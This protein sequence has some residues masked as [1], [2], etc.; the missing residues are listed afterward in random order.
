MTRTSASKLEVD[1]KAYMGEYT[2]Y[3]D[4]KA[5]PTKSEKRN[6]T[7]GIFVLSPK[8]AAHFEGLVKGSSYKITEIETPSK[9]VTV[10]AIT[11]KV[12]D[13]NGEAKITNKLKKTVDLKISK[14]VTNKSS[15]T[16]E[17]KF[18]LYLDG[19]KQTKFSYKL[20]NA[21]GTYST[22]TITDG[23]IKIKHGQ[24]ALIEGI[25]SGTKYEVRE[26]DVPD[27][28]T[29]VVPDNF[30]GILENTTEVKYING[31]S[32]EDGYV[33]LR[34]VVVSDDAADYNRQYTVTCKIG[35]NQRYE[36]IKKM[37][38]KTGE[39]SDITPTKKSNG[40]ILKYTRRSN[41]DSG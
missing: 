1:G 34:K 14:T 39:L 40:R 23:N 2:Y 20:Y 38:L 27:T 4:L 9:F 21:N 7:D 32:I 3:P 11:G 17:F 29:C 31:Y 28:Y 36:N 6:T 33:T 19:K 22:P 5:S 26:V 12:G 41:T 24:Y 10:A 16:T 30:K 18:N 8:A 15:D 35:Y 25:P 13:G 37:N